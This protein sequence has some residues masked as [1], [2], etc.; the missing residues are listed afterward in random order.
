MCSLGLSTKPNIQN[1][2]FNMQKN[3]F[4]YILSYMFHE[5]AKKF[6]ELRFPATK[7]DIMPT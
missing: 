7:G 4:K 6:K 5:M 3:L 1:P 2:I